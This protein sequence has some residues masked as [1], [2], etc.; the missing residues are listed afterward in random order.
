MFWNSSE[1]SSFYNDEYNTFINFAMYNFNKRHTGAELGLEFKVVDGF[2]ID[3]IA[4]VGQNIYTS[5]PTATISMENGINPDVEKIINCKGF[6]MDGAPEIATSVGF[7]YFHPSYWFFDINVN[8]FANTYLDFNP[9]RR[10]DDAIAGLNPDNEADAALIDRITRQEK[11]NTSIVPITVDASIGKSIRIKYKYFININLSAS[12]ILN[13]TNIKT[14]GYEQSRF[15]TT[16]TSTS[17]ETYLN[18]FPPK[19]FYAFGATIYLN[20]GFRF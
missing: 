13:N 19:Y 8:Y 11:L 2:T 16:N 18:R 20:V 12:N 4:A 6:H 3:A 17:R 15:S 14:G 10:T 5:N 9:L 1:L 7:H